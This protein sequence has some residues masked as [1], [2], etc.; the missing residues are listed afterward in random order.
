MKIQPNLTIVGTSFLLFYIFTFTDYI[1]DNAIDD[2]YADQGKVQISEDELYKYID[3][4]HISE[5]YE[6]E[7]NNLVNDDDDTNNENKFNYEDFFNLSKNTEYSNN[8]KNI[9]FNSDHDNDGY[10]QTSDLYI[11]LSGNGADDETINHIFDI[12][13][14]SRDPEHKINYKKFKSL[15]RIK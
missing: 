9:F 7:N 6:E 5:N 4:Q 8:L 13:G 1:G 2:V 15:F 11:M 12:K 14:I 3:K 10:I